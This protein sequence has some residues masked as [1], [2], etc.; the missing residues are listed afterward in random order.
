MIGS[1]I[2]GYIS[3]RQISYLHPLENLD[4]STTRRM[5]F[6][7]NF[8]FHLIAS[9]LF[10]GSLVALVPHKDVGLD[11]NIPDSSP[12]YHAE[13]MEN[14]AARKAWEQKRLADPA[15]GQIPK[16]IRQLELAFAEGLPSDATF[17]VDSLGAPWSPRG[18]WNLGGRTRAFAMDVTNSNVLIAGGVSGGIWRSTD[19]G[20]SWTRVTAA[21]QHPGVNSIVQDTRP[22]HTDTWYALSGEAYGTSASGGDAFYLGTGLFKSTDGGLTWNVVSS[23]N[24]GTPQT[25]DSVWDATWNVAVDEADTVNDVVYCALLGA[26]MRSGNGGTSWVRVLGSSSTNLSYF[27]NVMTTPT[28]KVY[29]TLSSYDGGGGNG[30][31]DQGIWRSADGGNW[32]DISPSFMPATYRRIVSVY[33]PLDEDRVYFLLANVDP[34]S[35][36]L[37]TDFQGDPEWNALY[38][39]TY[40]SGDGTGSGGFW[41]DLTQNIPATGGI[42]DKFVVQGSYDLCISINPMDTN[43]VIIGG[44][45]LYRS[46]TA[47][48]DSTNTR[49]IGGYEVGAGQPILYNGLY[50]NQHPDQHVMFWHPT[51]PNVLFSA[52]DGGIWRCDDVTD[53][54]PSWT[55]LNNG[56]LVS[57]FYTIGLDHGTPGSNVIVGGLQD[58]GTYWNNTTTQTDPWEWVAGGD[59]SYC[60][61]VDGGSMYYFSKQLGKVAKVTINGSGTVTGFERIDPIGA[62]GYEF[63]NP[64][65][66]DPNDQNVMYLPAGR[67]IWRNSDLSAIL[68]AGGWDSITTNWTVLP[69]TIAGT[70]VITAIGIT[71]TPANRLYV[72]TDNRNIYR[73]DNAHSGSPTMTQVAI[74]TMP[75]AGYVSCLAVHPDDGDK[76]IAVYSNYGVYSIWSTTDAGSTWVKAGGNLE[77][78]STGTGNGPSIR[79]VQILPWPTGDAYL[80]ATSVGLYATDTLNG[81]ATVWTQLAA[82][83]LGKAVVD[84]IDYRLSDGMAVIATHG[85]G[86]WSA[87]LTPPPAVNVGGGNG[88]AAP[89]VAVYPNPLT[90]NSQVQVDLPS[91]EHM[92]IRLYDQEGR[93]VDMMHEGRL[94]AGRNRLDMSM[95]G[96][97][98]GVYF[99]RVQGG[100]WSR[101]VKCLMVE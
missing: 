22:G 53:S 56:Y 27:T 35:G 51:L 23:T 29:A 1:P 84:M 20:T 57:Q 8:Y 11:S 72:G 42:F 10:L 12:L 33:N 16:G 59:G 49:H 67:K 2:A 18:P 58:N 77:Q 32:Y 99:C 73:I 86:I 26:I 46:T 66:V 9:A 82:G 60:H 4:R 100:D 15:T 25:F 81:T 47:F 13:G 96:L 78:N 62:S 38:R 54:V 80:A 90:A 41:E 50:P 63:I 89:T 39:Y 48:N 7:K 68:L 21:A 31:T 65:V 74:G 69:D 87:T 5:G 91:E 19:A 52:N 43:M 34:A 55:S 37:T 88:I 97:A 79:W 71:K 101:V 64:F 45:N 70:N 92:R 85:Y 83:T 14:S 93:L 44:T 75:S 24:S 28:G 3:T 6:M 17:K 30:G 95:D 94:S 36:K 40:L 61:I 98:S 76:V